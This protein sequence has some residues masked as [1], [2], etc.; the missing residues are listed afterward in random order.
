LL[1]FAFLG[2]APATASA[3]SV[4]LVVTPSDVVAG[5]PTEFRFTTFDTVDSRV[6]VYKQTTVAPC[7]GKPS[8]QDPDQYVDDNYQQSGE[9]AFVKTFTYP[10]P[11]TFRLC[12]YL[13]PTSADPG[14]GSI[15]ASAPR[16]QGTYD[17]A[18][19]GT[20]A[21]LAV[22]GIPATVGPGGM[23]DV[24]F[25]TTTES[26]RQVQYLLV[27]GAACPPNTNAAYVYASDRQNV[28]GGPVTGTARVDLSD[29]PTG[30][31]TWCGFVGADVRSGQVDQVTPLGTVTIAVPPAPAA[32]P[33]PP[34][35]ALVDRSA[36]R[37][38]AFRIRCYRM[39]SKF[40]RVRYK[41][42]GRSVT[43]SVRLKNGV[44]RAGTRGLAYGSW[45]V[46][47]LA[48]SGKVGSGRITVRRR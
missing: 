5:R 38:R 41:R 30:L 12:V 25:T 47:F 45:K 6:Y 15:K 34:A 39:P 13:Q 11:E 1:V 28:I 19:R 10:V 36:K 43:K 16:A 40:V 42:G 46:S 9:Q 23:F 44:A 22:T 27:P 33:K 29:S 35:C 4:G 17:I 26:S 20:R 32:T 14:T 18:V 48:D 31:Y 37:G 2:L 8:L 21:S 7:A 3:A 24:T